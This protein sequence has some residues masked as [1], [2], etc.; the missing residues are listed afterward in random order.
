MQPQASSIADDHK[1]RPYDDSK[2]RIAKL[3][4]QIFNINI[5]VLMAVLENKFKS[6]RQMLS[7]HEEEERGLEDRKKGSQ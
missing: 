6:F 5:I 4:S 3:E 7:S 2:E 1:R